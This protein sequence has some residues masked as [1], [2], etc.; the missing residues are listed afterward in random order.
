MRSNLTTIQHA[1]SLS[2]NYFFDELSESISES[3]S[4]LRLLTHIIDG[5]F[6]SKPLLVQGLIDLLYQIQTNLRLQLKS[7]GLM[8]SSDE[9]QELKREG[10]M[11][12]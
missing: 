6:G 12:A 11:Q 7:R 3:L 8:S 5:R 4:G 10:G 1:I 9:I 2:P